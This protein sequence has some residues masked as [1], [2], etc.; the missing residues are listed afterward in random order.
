MAMIFLVDS[1]W[2]TRRL[3]L[4][5]RHGKLCY[6]VFTNFQTVASQHMHF[7]VLYSCI[8]LLISLSMLFP[9]LLT[10]DLPFFYH[11]VVFS[12]AKFCPCCQCRFLTCA[13]QDNLEA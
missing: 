4:Q 11:L 2:D 8:V 5:H 7:C 6:H 13:V 12:D 1:A 10:L 9:F 3:M